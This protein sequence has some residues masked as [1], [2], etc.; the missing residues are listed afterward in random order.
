MQVKKKTQYKLSFLLEDKTYYAPFKTLSLLLDKDIN[1]I[2]KHQEDFLTL[3]EYK[4]F[5]ILQ[6]ALKDQEDYTFL[7]DYKYF[8]DQKIFLEQGV[9]VP[10]TDTEILIDKLLEEKKN[11]KTK[12]EIEVLEIGFGTG[13]ISIAL[14]KN[15]QWTFD[16]IDINLKAKQLAQ[17]NAEYNK[18]SERINF[19]LK[20][21][22]SLALTKRYDV[23]ISNPPYIN[24]EDKNVTKWVKENQPFEALYSKN[25]GLN[26]I[27]KILEISE[28]N[29]KPKG[30]LLFEFGFDQK[31]VITKMIDV[32]KWEIS[33]GKDLNNLWRYVLLR[34][35]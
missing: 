27:I 6:Q 22:F 33:F 3:E 32:T 25:D 4:R 20:D 19:L 14:A 5:V 8:Y 24:F 15:T 12:S 11:S 21:L 30:I 16:A 29:L 34:K 10:Q 35:K 7:V 17:K 31:E 18:V 28:K 23:I 9:F 1:W 13:A 26:H 2:L